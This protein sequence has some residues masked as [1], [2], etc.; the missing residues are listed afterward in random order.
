MSIR[1]SRATQQLPKYVY[2]V[3]NWYVY[4]PYLGVKN[5]KIIR[6]K[7]IKLCSCDRPLS[8]LWE[9]YNALIERR[10][11]TIGWMMQQYLGSKAFQKLSANTRKN[12][13]KWGIPH[14]LRAKVAAPYHTFAKVPLEHVDT[15]AIRQYLDS[16]KS[17][18]TVS[19]HLHLLNAGWKHAIQYHRHVPP[20]PCVDI[21]R[22]TSDKC[23]R[24][25]DD[26]LYNAVLNIASPRAY[27]LMEI[28]YICRARMQEI[29]KLRVDKHVL[30]DG[31]LIERVKRSLTEITEWTPRLKKA[32]A[33]LMAIRT[34]P[35]CPY[36]LQTTK[37]TAYKDYSSVKRIWSD[38]MRSAKKKGLVT[39]E[40]RFTHKDM[41]AK[42]VSD[43]LELMERLKVR[44]DPSISGHKAAHSQN[45]YIRKPLHNKG[46]R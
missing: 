38:L 10:E 23:E 25:V 44:P 33:K 15:V 12:Y 29:L 21:T 3:N 46:T 14:L 24:Y 18:N 22:E 31:L 13:E 37:G 2:K 17:K 8:E 19:L 11:R 30:E 4:R 27:A 45:H 42:G 35:H 41:K 39:E 9:R 28:G 40:T 26:A 43:H 16:L 34:N 7:D 6:G 20:N 36:L 1:R 5:K 32:V